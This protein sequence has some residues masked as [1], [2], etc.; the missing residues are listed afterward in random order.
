MVEQL[1]SEDADIVA[2]SP[3]HPRGGFPNLPAWKEA[4]ARAISRFNARLLPGRLTCYTSLFRAYRREWFKPEF[5]RS[6]DFRNLA[7]ILVGAIIAGAKVIEYPVVLKQ[8]R[9]RRPARRTARAT[10]DHLA[11][12]GSMLLRGTPPRGD[13]KPGYVT[14]QEESK[15]GP[16]A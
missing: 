6:S 1:Q 14:L 4:R 13:D 7:Q 15:R 11:L 9:R 8:Q 10:L 16:S 12:L 5:L 3:F 2:A